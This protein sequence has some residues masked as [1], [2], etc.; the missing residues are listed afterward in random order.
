MQNS[1][2][3]DEQAQ[4]GDTAADPVAHEAGYN[5]FGI[6]KAVKVMNEGGCVARDGWNGKGQFLTLQKPDLNSLMTRPYVYITTVAGA[7][8]PWLCSQ[9]DLLAV[10]WHQV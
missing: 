9:E 4:G 2:S 8:V 7:R 1:P 3:A 10:D 6:G 5:F